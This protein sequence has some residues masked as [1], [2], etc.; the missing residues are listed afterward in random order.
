M[1]RRKIEQKLRFWL[2]NRKQALLIDGAR[3]IG[4]THS[5]EHFIQEN[6]ESI[7]KIDFSDRTDLIDVFALLKNSDDLIR[8]LSLVAGDKLIEGKTVIFFDEIQ[9]VYVRRAELKD[10][11]E[12]PPNSQ[13]ILTAMKALVS[14]G[15]YRYI[16]SGSLLGITVKDVVLN[17]TGYLDEYKMYP[18]DFEEFLWAKGVGEIAIEHVKK[19]FIE[20]TPIDPAIN[21]T[22]LSYFREYVLVGGM[23][24]AVMAYTEKNNLFVVKEAHDQILNRY[25]QDITTYIKD[26]NLKLRVRDVLTRSLRNC[27]AKTQGIF[28][29]KS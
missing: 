22:L 23:P 8:R 24:E 28:L 21:E 16:L 27:P 25:R 3:Q 5:I 29:R 14:K 26:D 6:F 10:K 17:P 18:L 19:C 12:L 15:Q 2:E 7:V 1:L 20:K 9:L 4:K 13:D 11:G